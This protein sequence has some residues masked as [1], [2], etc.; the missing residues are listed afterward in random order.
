MRRFWPHSVFHAREG[1]EHGPK[2]VGAR[3]LSCSWTLQQ[4]ACWEDL[5]VLN[6]GSIISSST[7][8]SKVVKLPR[9]TEITTGSVTKLQLCGFTASAVLCVHL[10][11]HSQAA[12]VL[13]L[14]EQPWNCTSAP[15]T[16]VNPL[17]KSLILSAV[18]Q[19]ASSG[20]L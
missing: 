14:S 2:T 18:Q 19:L 12:D 15:Q 13:Y 7:E 5:K 20:G 8:G 9:C 16:T 10:E 3:V 1:L 11:V 17:L 6:P 4:G